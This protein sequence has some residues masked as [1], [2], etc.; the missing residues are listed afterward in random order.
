MLLHILKA[1]ATCFQGTAYAVTGVPCMIVQ[2]YLATHV[3]P[4]LHACDI[5]EQPDDNTDAE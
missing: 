4:Q 2:C 5:I 1:A 3:L